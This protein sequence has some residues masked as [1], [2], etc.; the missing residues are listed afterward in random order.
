[1]KKCHWSVDGERLKNGMWALGYTHY[2]W[3]CIHKPRHIV[4]F[5]KNNW[6]TWLGVTVSIIVA[7]IVTNSCM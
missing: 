1:M 6:K 4:R 2:E 5:L 3:W 7:L